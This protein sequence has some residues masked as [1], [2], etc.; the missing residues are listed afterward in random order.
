MI[1]IIFK[2]QLKFKELPNNI[3]EILNENNFQ[4]Y[5]RDLYFENNQVFISMI[6]KSKNGITINIY[7][8]D[9]NFDKIN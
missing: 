2:R 1:K 6:V 4:H 3:N 8:A 5:I 9:L 7:K